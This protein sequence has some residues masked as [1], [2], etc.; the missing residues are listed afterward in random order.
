MLDNQITIDSIIL[1]NNNNINNNLYII[2]CLVF[3]NIITRLHSTTSFITL[4]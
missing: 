4:F 2:K 3:L 1:G